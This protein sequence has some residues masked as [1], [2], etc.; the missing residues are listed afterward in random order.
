MAGERLAGKIAVVTGAASGIGRAIAEVFAEEG[1]DVT[2]TDINGEGAAAA[3]AELSARGLMASAM[4][5]DVA[6]GQDVSALF[7]S[8]EARHGRIDV[9]VNNAGLNVRGDFRHMSDADWE[10]IRDVNLDGVVR[11][12]RDGF[13][14]LKASGRGSLINLASIMGHRGLRQLTGYSATKGAV[15]AL[16]RGLAVEYAPFNIRVNALAPGFVETALTDRV[17]RNPAM[18]KALIDRT[19]LRRF[20]SGRD[21]AYAALYFASDES[22]FVTGAELAVDGGMA[23]GL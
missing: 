15:S 17:L 20:G 5:V 23:A 11:I 2:L 8:L 16:T 9:L 3:A 22:A 12:A 4:T 21:V 13:A 18:N 1:A 10:K 14:L 7:R 6:R 19:P